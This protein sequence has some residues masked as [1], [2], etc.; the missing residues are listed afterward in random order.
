MET[1]SRKYFFE[2]RRN[3][4]GIRLNY[5]IMPC[6]VKQSR[7]TEAACIFVPKISTRESGTFFPFVG[8]LRFYPEESRQRS[9]NNASIVKEIRV[10]IT[11]RRSHDN[12]TSFSTLSS[13]SIWKRS[14]ADWRWVLRTR[15]KCRMTPNR[16][17]PDFQSRGSARKL[18]IQFISTQKSSTDVLYSI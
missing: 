5:K 7:S 3:Y 18:K 6:N 14:W 17:Q 10:S 9:F 1:A 16:R 4:I 8:R 2:V 15:W 11:H 12:T 13:S